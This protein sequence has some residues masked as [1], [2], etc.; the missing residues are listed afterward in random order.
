MAYNW[1]VI[2]ICQVKAGKN[3]LPLSAVNAGK[4]THVMYTYLKSTV[5]LIRPSHRYTSFAPLSDHMLG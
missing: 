3:R 1:A 5:L 4:N 2:Y